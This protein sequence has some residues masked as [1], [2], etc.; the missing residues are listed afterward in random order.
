MSTSEQNQQP[1]SSPSSDS[2]SP[3]VVDA[4]E[5]R[6]DPDTVTEPAPKKQ[7]N[8]S[9]LTTGA[10]S[11]KRHTAVY[12]KFVRIMKLALPT[13]AIALL[14][15]ILLWPQLQS[16]SN[17]F[18]VGISGL[19]PRDPNRLKVVNARFRGVDSKGQPYSIMA[20]AAS[21]A[22]P[23]SRVI[24]LESPSA[25]MMQTDGTWILSNAPE[26]SFDLD[27]EVLKLWGGVTAFYDAGYT[28]DSPTAQVLLKEGKAMGDDPVTAYGPAGEIEGQ[29]GFEIL[30]KGRRILFK[31][32]SRLLLRPGG[33]L[34]VPGS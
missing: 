4:E 19:D 27:Q 12:H 10:Q 11:E 34:N 21:E 32:K 30:D 29:S 31:G 23:G 22:T 3:E 18:Q 16:E 33:S 25:D 1:V 2:P 26:G 6:S 5:L 15:A 9:F 20:E 24:A 17:R 13:G 7:D 28:L 8:L 14:G